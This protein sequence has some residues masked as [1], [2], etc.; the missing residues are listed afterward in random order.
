MK[1]KL[2][3]FLLFSLSF[4][5]SCNSQDLR[6]KFPSFDDKKCMIDYPLKG[7]YAEYVKREG[8]YLIVEE[9]DFKDNIYFL[10]L[11]RIDLPSF[12]ISVEVLNRNKTS[13]PEHFSKSMMNYYTKNNIAIKDVQH[14]SLSNEMVGKISKVDFKYS[15][16][17]IRN[18][19]YSFF[20]ND[21]VVTIGYTIPDSIEDVDFDDDILKLNVV[22]P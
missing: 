1:Y 7:E 12:Y 3:L 13:S 5:Q 21:K 14:K 20:I 18:I 4:M 9:N 16:N 22:C 17:N 15:S 8:D 2:P 11:N 6:L 10:T 19:I